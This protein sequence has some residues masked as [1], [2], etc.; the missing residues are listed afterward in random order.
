MITVQAGQTAQQFSVDGPCQIRV[1]YDG[2]IYDLALF[3]PGVDV[4]NGTPIA[5]DTT[6]TNPKYI[7]Q[8]LT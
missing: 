7:T 4:I 3:E 2:P 6:Q 5:Y 8:Y 1:K